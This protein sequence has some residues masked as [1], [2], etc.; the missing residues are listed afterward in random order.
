VAVERKG[1]DR[2]RLNKILLHRTQHQLAIRIEA[3]IGDAN[4]K[5]DN[6]M[7][8]VEQ[9]QETSREGNARKGADRPDQ[10]KR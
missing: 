6:R 5:I 9:D 10:G 1:L 8:K 4:R 7:R 2:N 3:V